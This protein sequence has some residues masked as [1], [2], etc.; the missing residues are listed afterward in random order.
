VYHC[1]ILIKWGSFL[2]LFWQGGV[3]SL[4]PWERIEVFCV[5]S[6]GFVVPMLQTE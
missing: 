1:N 3:L 4:T 6:L 2:A 5:F